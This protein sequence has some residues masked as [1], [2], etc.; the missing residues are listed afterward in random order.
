MYE[1]FEFLPIIGVVTGILPVDRG[2][3]SLEIL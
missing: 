2:V 3:K 1:E